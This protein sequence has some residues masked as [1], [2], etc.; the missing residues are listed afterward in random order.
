MKK[1]IRVVVQRYGTEINGGA[2]QHARRIAERLLGKYN[3][4]VITSTALEYTTWAEYY[5]PGRSVVNGVDVIRFSSVCTRN[6]SYYGEQNAKISRCID[7]GRKIPEELKEQWLIAQGLICPDMLEYI[8]EVSPETHAFLFVTYLFYPVI[9]GLPLVGEKSMFIPTA[10]DERYIYYDFFQEVF[11]APK[12]YLF[13]SQ[14]E[15]DF[16]HKLFHNKHIRYKVVGEGVDKPEKVYPEEFKKKFDIDNYVLYVGRIDSA[17]GCDRLMKYF[18]EYKRRYPSDLKLGFVGKQIIPVIE[19]PDIKYIG[20]ISDQEKFDGLAGARLLIMPSHYESLCMSL[21]ESLSVGTPVIA[22]AECDVNRGHCVRS[23]AG[24]YFED[25]FQ[26]E[27]CMN[28]LLGNEELYNQM[29]ENGIRY[30]RDNYNWN[31]VMDRID[32]IMED[33][34]L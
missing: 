5:K 24:L 34:N 10:H 22:N 3:V 4:E 13:N 7:E 27:M 20:F 16:V 9:K 21:L 25:Y 6:A 17:K 23:N 29:S 18:A 32:E 8:K 15:A 26:F 31:I 11:H 2:E 33:Y 28:Y 14:E 19:H 12:D 30:I 1:T